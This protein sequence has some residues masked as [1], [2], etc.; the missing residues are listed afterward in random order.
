MFKKGKDSNNENVSSILISKDGRF[1]I[2]A[3]ET[4]IYIKSM[5]NFATFAKLKVNFFKIP[6]IF[7][8]I[9]ISSKKETPEKICGMMLDASEKTLFVSV[10]D[11]KLVI[12]WNI[13]RTPL[14]PI[15]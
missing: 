4:S 3:A 13:N 10:L 11:G 9:L 14:L 6:S 5:T 1:F 8:Q 15:S 2:L 12:Y 7:M